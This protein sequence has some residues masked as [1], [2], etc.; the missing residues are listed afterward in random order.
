MAD[1]APHP[2]LPG[3]PPPTVERGWVVYVDLD[4]Y[5]V[6]CEL[7]ERPELVGRPVIVGPPP[8][9]GPSRGVVLSA[10]YEARAFGVH[11]AQPVSQAAR[12]CPTAAWVPPDFAKY[13]RVAEEVRRL[14]HRFSSDVVPF[15]IDE[16]ALRLPVAPVEEVRALAQRV[17]SALRSELGLPASLGVASTRAVAK[18]ATDRA[19]PGGIL[20]VPPGTEASFLAPLPVRA[21][22]GVGPKTE[23]LLHAAGVTTIGE[24]AASRPADLARSVGPFARELIVLARGEGVDLIEEAAGPRSRSTDRTFPRDVEEWP[25]VEAAL[26]ELSADLAESLAKEGL[27]YAGVGVAFRWSDFTRS[28]RSRALGAAQEGAPALGVVAARLA[29]ELWDAERSG[30]GRSVRTVSVRTERLSERRQRQESLDSFGPSGP[31][32]ASSERGRSPL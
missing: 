9:A 23:E 26:R 5:Y 28:Q 13:G 19:K 15:S 2:G 18:I 11:S 32:P 7:R 24:L 6:S 3:V 14:L 17:Q 21:I 25:E 27:R 22:P 30:R 1:E 4:A 20:V 16:A 31:A 10:S 12:L 8:S 29:R